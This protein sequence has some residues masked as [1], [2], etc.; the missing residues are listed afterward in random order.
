MEYQLKTQQE[1]LNYEQELNAKLKV[2]MERVHSNQLKKIQM[3]K[4]ETFKLDQ[5]VQ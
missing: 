5:L 2:E 4:A 1:K 3:Y